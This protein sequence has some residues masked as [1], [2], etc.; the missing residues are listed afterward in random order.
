M[1]KNAGERRQERQDAKLLADLEIK[2]SA[3]VVEFRKTYGCYPQ[4]VALPTTMERFGLQR[5]GGVPVIY[6][7]IADGQESFQQGILL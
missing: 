3:A 7:P 4:L 5:L 2:M 1:A 6:T